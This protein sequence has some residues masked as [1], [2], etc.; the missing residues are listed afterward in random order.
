MGNKRLLFVI[1]ILLVAVALVP[2]MAVLF[3]LPAS[4]SGDQP[5]AGDPEVR[6]VKGV[7]E[8]WVQEGSKE[9]L[10]VKIEGKTERFLLKEGSTEHAAVPDFIQKGDEIGLYYHEDGREGKIAREITS[11]DVQG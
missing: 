2:L 7:Y 1:I 6:W 9:W 8:N 11:P 10:E 3:L 4:S 5:G